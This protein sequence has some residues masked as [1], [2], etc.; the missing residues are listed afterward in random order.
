MLD[1]R[2][3]TFVLILWIAGLL[4]GTAGGQGR[5]LVS[6]T[7]D[8]FRIRSDKNVRPQ[9]IRKIGRQLEYAYAICRDR[10]GASLQRKIDVYAFSSGDRYRAESRSKVYDDGAF[11]D[12]KIF[13]DADAALR[14]DTAQSN[15][16][17]RVVAEAILDE[18]KSC[19]RWLAEVYGICAGRDLSRFGPPAQLTASTFSDLTEDYARAETPEEMTEVYA[20]LASTARFLIGRYGVRKIE[21]MYTQFRRAVT[22]EEAFE[23]AFGEK[24]PVIEKAWAESLKSHAKG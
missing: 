6:R 12:G 17:A 13:F 23:A 15:P 20:K 16:F 21:Q 1:K 18:F 8:N 14:C 11:R 4:P 24:M 22:L 5:G 9:D 2:I 10:L 3:G 19:P 7:T